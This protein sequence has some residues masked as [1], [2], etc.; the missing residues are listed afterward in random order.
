M[1]QK[2]LYQ[3]IKAA[4]TFNI[5]FKVFLIFIAVIFIILGR[6]SGNFLVSH[7][8]KER[9]RVKDKAAVMTVNLNMPSFD[10]L[11]E[12]NAGRG[13]D[14]E[15]LKEYVKYYEQIIK[16]QPAS[17]G[18]YGMLGFCYYHL[19]DE[20]KAIHSY[21]KAASLNPYFFWFYHNLGVIHFRN[22]EYEK[23][24][25]FFKQ[26]A[27]LD[28]SLTLTAILSSK[29]YRQV[30][31]GDKDFA[32]ELKRNLKLG[33]EACY[34]LLIISSYGRAHPENIPSLPVEEEVFIHI[35]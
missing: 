18:S 5:I 7:M 11:I 29:V 17:W 15:F 10:G 34:K 24:G 28:P 20:E 14:A 32:K 26:A 22:G 27:D 31:V 25:E 21:E 2:I 1:R 9:E 12:F 19:G 6:L 4:G 23:A 8:I 3:I 35:F 13:K 16:Y 33:Y 30:R